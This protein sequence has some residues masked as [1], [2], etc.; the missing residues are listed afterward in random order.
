LAEVLV[1]TP[2]TVLPEPEV[3]QSTPA[4]EVVEPPELELLELPP[5]QAARQL[6]TAKLQNIFVFMTVSKFKLI[7]TIKYCT[8]A[9]V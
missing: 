8:Q 7:Q 5:P 2:V 3:V 1:A 6:A 4:V 9:Q